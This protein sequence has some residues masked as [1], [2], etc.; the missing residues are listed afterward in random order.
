MSNH[1]S[2]LKNQVNN[3]HMLIGLLHNFTVLMGKFDLQSSNVK[4]N[5]NNFINNTKNWSSS[6]MA[7][8]YSFNTTRDLSYTH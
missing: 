4:T 8:Q 2:V 3:D 1:V 7:D 6:K 5:N